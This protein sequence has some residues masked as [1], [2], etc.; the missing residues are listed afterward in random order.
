MVT[1]GE[2]GDHHAHGPDVA[3]GDHRPHVR[4]ERVSGVPVVHRTDA[5]GFPRQADDLLAFLDGHRH[6]LLAEHVKPR[7]KEGTGDLEMRR[8][9]RGDSDEIDPI[10]SGPLAVQHLAPV[11]VG[12]VSGKAEPPP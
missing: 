3:T 10:R 12:A 1:M 4:D 7:G 6:R 9:R 5:A 8:V 11:A 2:L